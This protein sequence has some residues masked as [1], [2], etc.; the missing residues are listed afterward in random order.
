MKDFFKSVLASL[1]ALI[2]YSFVFF[3]LFAGIAGIVAA[4]G[5]KSAPVK[6][7]SVLHLN[8]KSAITDRANGNISMTSL[9]SGNLQQGVGLNDILECISR[10]KTDDNIKCI[11][12]DNSDINANLATIAE[13]RSAVADFKQSGKPVYAYADNLSQG[14]YYLAS[15][16]DKIEL[17]PTGEMLLKGL[18]AQV[19]FYKGALD[20]LGVEVQVFR[21]GKFKSA[22]EPYIL[23]GMSAENR[24]QYQA[25]LDAMWQVYLQNIAES[26]SIDIAQLNNIADNG[27]SHDP[28]VAKQLGLI[29][30]VAYRDDVLNELVQLT[31]VENIDKLNFV[32]V[33]KYAKAKPFAMPSDN[34]IAVVYA[35]GE[36]NQQ[37]SGY[38]EQEI[39]EKVYV[40]ALRDV[41]AD[42]SIKAVVLRVNSPGG[43]A[44]VSDNIWHEVELTKQVKPV[45]VS[46]GD[47]A[48]SGGYYISCPASYIVANEYTL[49]GSIGVFGLALNIQKLMSNK[50]GINTEVVKTN[51]MSDFGNAYRSF[52]PAEREIMQSSVEKI[53]S[54]FV[55]RVSNGRNLLPE[56]VDSIGQGRVWCGVDALRL[57]LIDAYGGLTDAISIAAEMSGT[58]KYSL[59]DYPKQEEGFEAMM[60]M[61]TEEMA[62]RKISKELGEFAESAKYIKNLIGSQGVQARMENTIEIY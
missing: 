32:S 45:V 49:T 48:A 3:I 13:I 60:K 4:F 16:A 38:S 52:T 51:K 17:N 41:R 59:V 30:E 11:F 31:G 42:S 56:S 7:N 14:I 25:M 20:K 35:S 24:L 43:S 10:A 12:I 6:P 9:M 54:T 15:V 8:F 19:M 28:Q 27:L 5:D 53:Y 18:Q 1:V 46:M 33:G 22:V 29:D 21:H 55:S 62:T 36:I 26:R 61:L 23:S 2:L 40:E 44:Q 57:H 37:S 47:Y 58:E 39:T 50:L 34:K